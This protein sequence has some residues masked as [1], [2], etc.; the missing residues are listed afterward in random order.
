MPLIEGYRGQQFGIGGYGRPVV[1]VALESVGYRR[2][3]FDGQ[4]ASTVSG[5]KQS[6]PAGSGGIG[7]LIALVQSA[8]SLVT[9]RDPEDSTDQE[10]ILLCE[11]FEQRNKRLWRRRTKIRKTL[12]F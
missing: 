10:A 9:K 1:A 7:S 4:R 5:S 8:K 11:S 12:A 2:P 3:L 6:K